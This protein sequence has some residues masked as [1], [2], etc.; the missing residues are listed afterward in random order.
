MPS[1]VWKRLIGR[2][3]KHT[4]YTHQWAS[5]YIGWEAKYMLMASC[6]S[7]QDR[8]AARSLGW[9]T[10]TVTAEN[11]PTPALKAKGDILCPASK[12]AGQRT[13]C[14]RCGLCSGK[15]SA[16]KSISIPAHGMYKS[17]AI[18]LLRTIH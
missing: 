5:N 10:F 9:R 16:A 12:E 2:A 7:E 13:T 15:A 1:Y 4:G 6:D 17:K 11:E 8:L 14:E 3:E 18:S